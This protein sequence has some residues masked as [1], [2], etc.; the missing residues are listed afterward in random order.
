M[1]YGIEFLNTNKLL[2]FIDKVT[3]DDMINTLEFEENKDELKKWII[4]IL[5]SI[6]RKVISKIKKSKDSIGSQSRFVNNEW[7]TIYFDSKQNKALSSRL[8]TYST[9]DIFIFHN[10]ILQTTVDFIGKKEVLD[11]FYKA[12]L[13]ELS[14]EA[15]SE[16]IYRKDVDSMLDLFNDP[17]YREV[18]EDSILPALSDRFAEQLSLTDL[19]FKSIEEAEDAYEKSKTQEDL[20]QLKKLYI[21][22]AEND[23]K[24]CFDHEDLRRMY[25]QAKFDCVRRVITRRSAYLDIY[26]Y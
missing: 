1:T 4:T 23:V 9:D 13:F 16:T 20:A 6:S 10:T 5:T 25:D 21:I 14:H 3:K 24:N 18:R 11:I 17:R 22:K 8:D 2:A 7:V 12:Y 26:G 15:A 19:R